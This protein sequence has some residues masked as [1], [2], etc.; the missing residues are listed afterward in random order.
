LIWIMP[1]SSQMSKTWDPSGTFSSHT[2]GLA[3]G[4]NMLGHA[5]EFLKARKPDRRAARAVPAMLVA[6]AGLAVLASCA[7]SSEL[8]NG[9]GGQP[10]PVAEGR[11]FASLGCASCHAMDQNDFGPNPNAP[12][13][14]R[15]LPRLEFKML[16]RATSPNVDM[17]HGAMPPLRLSRLDRD[18]LVAYLKSL[19]GASA[20]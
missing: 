7:S 8:A 9:S 19:E 3:M 4:T 13:M 5:P 20:R 16:E 15:L 1:S 18:A 17:I 10:D 2:G 6:A 14:K 12:P 11:E